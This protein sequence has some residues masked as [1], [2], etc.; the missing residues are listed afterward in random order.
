[1]NTVPAATDTASHWRRYRV[2]YLLIAVCLAP[3]VASYVL[4]YAAP[5]GGRTNYGELIA[6]Q[7]LPA[8]DARLQDGTPF[9]LR[10]LR[11]KWVMLN[12]DAAACEADCRQRLWQMRQLRLATGKDAERIERV[13]LVTDGAPLETMLMREHDGTHFLRG[14]RAQLAAVFTPA[15][16]AR[17]EDHV[18]LVDPL[19]NLM[20][21]W[22]R[23]ADPQRMKKDL[24]KLLKASR[25]G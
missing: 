24:Q 21:R 1:L 18:Y 11:G 9:D 4:Y 16:G 15:A 19:G 13:F 20:L 12:V 22:P 7:P 3:V 5:P 14:D 6:Q 25:I 8:L 17:M 2:L 23:D 10:T